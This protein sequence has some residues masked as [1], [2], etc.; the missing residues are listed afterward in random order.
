MI[1]EVIGETSFSDLYIKGKM[2]VGIDPAHA[3]VHINSPDITP[4]R[5]DHQ[6]N[7]IFEI[8]TDGRVEIISSVSG[9]DGSVSNYPLYLDAVD[10]GIAIKVDG[11]A[12]ADNNFISFWDNSG[13]VG[14]V[15]GESSANW[16]AYPPYIARNVYEVAI[17]VALVAALAALPVEPA[18]AISFAGDVAYVAAQIGLELANL[19]VTYASAS[20]DYAEWLEKADIKEVFKAGDI[21]GIYGGKI[22]KSTI[23]ADQLSCISFSPIVLGNQPDKGKEDL[24]EMVAF[25][26]QIPVKVIGPVNSGDFIIP[27]GLHDGSGIAVAPELMTVDEFARIVG[28]AWSSSEIAA[29]KY[30]NAAIGFSNRE[31]VDI[32]LD[33]KEKN[34]KLQETLSVREIRIQ[35]AKKELLELES[36]FVEINKKIE[37]LVEEMSNNINVQPANSKAAKQ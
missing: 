37:V 11:N 7:K 32:L 10:Q 31:I 25:L 14:R 21:V 29:P 22:S 1:F 3:K 35:D 8:E 12:D 15:E 18:S 27:S 24:F 6:N 9:N 17:G 26:G 33:Q 30:V 4:F 20:G 23:G 5:V 34:I 28:R 36:Q 16:W 2:G 19:G 13:M